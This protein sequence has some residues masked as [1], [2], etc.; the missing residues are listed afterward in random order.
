LI[1]RRTPQSNRTSEENKLR[2][3]EREERRADQDKREIKRRMTNTGLITLTVSFQ[4][5]QVIHFVQVYTGA[6][7]ERGAQTVSELQTLRV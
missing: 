7:R 4:T 3:Q 5:S 2:T 6:G 1:L